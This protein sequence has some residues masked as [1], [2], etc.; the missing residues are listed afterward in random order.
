MPEFDINLSEVTYKPPLQP[1]DYTFLV[2][3][4]SIEQAKEP[5]KR[6]G[7]REWYI[8]AE[9]KPVEVNGYVVFHNWSLSAAALQVED[10]TVS[11]KKLYEVANWPIGAKINSDDL[12]SFRIVAKTKLD[13]FN[14]RLNPKLEKVLSATTS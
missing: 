10:P 1:G 4:T 7:E 14:G 3:K 5:N 12:L 13:S 9:L 8:K 2:L 11:I 6:T